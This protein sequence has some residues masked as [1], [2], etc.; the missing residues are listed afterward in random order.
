MSHSAKA[1]GELKS[2]LESMQQEVPKAANQND[3]TVELVEMNID[4]DL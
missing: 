3:C 1:H 2:M 4:P